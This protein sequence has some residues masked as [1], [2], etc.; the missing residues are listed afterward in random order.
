MCDNK[1]IRQEIV[2]YLCGDDDL[3]AEFIELLKAGNL[4]EEDG[5]IIREKLTGQIDSHYTL[6]CCLKTST[7]SSLK[8]QK[9]IWQ[10]K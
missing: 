8:V 1:Q 10:R 2:T 7:G 6:I 3:S 4:T 9:T 5:K